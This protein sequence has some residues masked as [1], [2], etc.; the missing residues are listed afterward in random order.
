[1]KSTV[2]LYLSILA[3]CSS[4]SRFPELHE[5]P[6]NDQSFKG[7][8]IFQE[9]SSTT[10]FKVLLLNQS[11]EITDQ[12]IFRY[13]PYRFD[14]ADVNQDGKTEIIVG[15]TKA[16]RFDPS[17][18]KRLFIL[19]IDDNQIRPMWLGSKVCQ[20]L[21]DFKSLDNGYLQTLERTTAGKFS[22]GKYYWQSFGL[23][24]ENYT[25]N[26]ITLDYANQIFRN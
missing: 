26:E 14:T 5:F 21:I 16:T 11:G 19:R 12:T 10:G 18:K 2:V 13:V 24:L 3:A 22:I 20:E 8:V 25:H 9:L 17:E 7:K 23:T 4:G 15:L 1:M 6:I